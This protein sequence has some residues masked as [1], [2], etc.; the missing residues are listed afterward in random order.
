MA[1]SEIEITHEISEVLREVPYC[2]NDRM[3]TFYFEGIVLAINDWHTAKIAEIVAEL[4]KMKDSIVYSFY[5][6]T[7][8][9]KSCMQR[10]WNDKID[11][12]IE[13]VKGGK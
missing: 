13:R 8:N 5:E 10:D 3:S 7:D 12:L 2:T 6:D 11:A 1:M 9:S 4:E